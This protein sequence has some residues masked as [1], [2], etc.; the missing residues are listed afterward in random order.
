MSIK[1]LIQE[2][3]RGL[4]EP[5]YLLYAGD[6]F[7]LK[8][9]LSIIKG[10]VPEERKDFLYSAYDAGSTE[11]KVEEFIRGLYSSPFFVG[12]GQRQTVVLENS[13]ELSDKETK[14]LEEYLKNPSPDT[15]LVLLYQTQKGRIAP[16]HKEKLSTAVAIPVGVRQSD[17]SLWIKEKTSTMGI[18][19]TPEAMEYLLEEMGA[20]FGSISSE[21]EKLSRVGKSVIDKSDLREIIKG[22]RQYD[23][24][25]L[26]RAIADGDRERVFKIYNAL[27]DE[28][29]AES[30]LGAINWQYQSR[31]SVKIFEILNDADIRLKSSASPCLMEEVLFKLLRY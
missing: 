30:L 22:S 31:P 25:D 29:P 10:S 6:E 24:F 14:K 3:K 11:F 13:H 17:I 8:E 18:E 9:A 4:K 28:A 12:G 2:I 15:I 1:R 16:A 7:F 27:R 20:D 19:L 26:T 5:S 23:V 21:L